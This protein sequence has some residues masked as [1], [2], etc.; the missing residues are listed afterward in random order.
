MKLV[1]T[2]I[3]RIMAILT[4][5]SLVAFASTIAVPVQASSPQPAIAADIHALPQPPS[6]FNPLSA[7]PAELQMYGFPPKPTDGGALQAWEKAVTS[8][9]HWVNPQLYFIYGINHSEQQPPHDTPDIAGLPGEWAGIAVQ[10]QY[11]SNIGYYLTTT[12][13]HVPNYQ[14][15]QGQGEMAS[16]WTG[17]G[18][19]NSDTLIQAGVDVN[20]TYYSSSWYQAHGFNVPA[21]TNYAAWWQY[22]NGSSNPTGYLQNL[23][24]SAGDDIYISVCCNQ[25]SPYSAYMWYADESN[26]EYAS[27]Q[28]NLP[29]GYDSS[30]ADWEYERIAGTEETIPHVSFINCYLQNNNATWGDFDAFKWTRCRIG[31]D[32]WL[33][34]FVANY[35]PV[36][37]GTSSFTIHKTH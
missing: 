30:S 37:I 21:G 27:F 26:G 25:T 7:T 32:D 11:N 1:K 2:K 19:M 5:T 24:V 28:E 22:I 16:Y 31:N 29:Q 3:F 18:G 34:N 6:G 8:A 17:I 14:K 36:N 23:T 33:G 10:S 15:G 9:K 12:E 35:E 4:I 20:M 13:F